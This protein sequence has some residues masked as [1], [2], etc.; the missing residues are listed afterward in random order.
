MRPPRLFLEEIETA[1]LLDPATVADG[2]P[3]GIPHRCR[4]RELHDEGVSRPLEVELRIP[5][6]ADGAD[7]ELPV[8]VQGDGLEPGR[9]ASTTV[10]PTARRTAIESQSKLRTS[11]RWWIKS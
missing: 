5:R 1:A 3:H 9:S 8:H 10:V 4:P 11:M 6:S 7:L 2:E